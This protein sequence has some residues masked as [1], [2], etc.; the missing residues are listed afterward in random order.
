M[1]DIQITL[2]L[3]ETLIERVKTAGLDIQ[4]ITPDVIT[5]L[6]QRLAR[7]QAWQYLVDTANQ[8]QGSLTPEAIDAELAAAKAERIASVDNQS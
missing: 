3:P 4:S 1:S 6:E 2:M 7:K 5:L 8:L